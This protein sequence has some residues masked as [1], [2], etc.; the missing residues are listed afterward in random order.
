MIRCK[1]KEN[2]NKQKSTYG[3]I[4]YLNIK[5]GIPVLSGV[6]SCKRMFSGLIKATEATES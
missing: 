6:K 4:Y 3:I 5:S 1:N 2:K